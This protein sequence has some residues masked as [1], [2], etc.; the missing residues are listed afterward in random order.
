M[1]GSQRL[2][3]ARRAA[4]ALLGAL[5]A[6][7][8][9]AA[10]PAPEEPTPAPAAAPAPKWYE[11]VDVKGL[12]SASW[13]ANGNRPASGTNALRAFDAEDLSIRLDVA[14]LVVQRPA[15]EPGEAGFRLDALAGSSV[16]RL[17]AARGLFR[18][19]GTGEAGDFDLLQAYFSWIAP[20]GHGL[21]VDVGKFVT[22]V[23]YEAIDG[24]ECWNDHATRSFLFSFSEPST[25]TGLK[26]GYSFSH[27]VSAEALLVN[28]W[29]DAKDVN[30]SKTVGAGLTVTPGGGWTLSANLLHGP[31]GEGNDADD[32]SLLGV[33]ARLEPGGAVSAALSFERGREEGLACGGAAATWWGVSGYVRWAVSP[34]LALGLRAERF[35]DADGVRTGT[36]QRLLGLTLTPAVSLGSGFVLR[37]DLRVDLSDEPVFEDADG[38]FTRKRQPT[39]LLNAL[40][41]F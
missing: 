26:A 30:R 8:A 15:E 18:D 3:P 7:S 17:T 2:L 27:V 16:P 39:L 35:E 19:A 1:A 12:V 11:T 20:L 21:K 9:P 23:G 10:Q 25:H 24:P 36:A 29:D 41:A 13:S 38:L 6:A 4:A 14:A 32:R 33:T 22:S 40:Y 34:V 28:G 37:A 31:E 5:W